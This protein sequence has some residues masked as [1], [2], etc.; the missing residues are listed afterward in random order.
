MVL[1]SLLSKAGA[2]ETC[3]PDA[4]E[5]V[6]APIASHVLYGITNGRRLANNAPDNVDMIFIGDSILEGWNKFIEAD[7]PNLSIWNFSVGSDRT[8]NVLWRFSILDKYPKN[9]KAIVLLIGTNNFANWMPSCAINAGIDEII[10]NIDSRWPNSHLFI[11]DILP[12]GADFKQYEEE[13]VAVNLHLEN[14]ATS[15]GK[16]THIN[17]D[18]TSFTCNGGIPVGTVFNSYT[19]V[20]SKV[21]RCNN[22]KDDNVHL[23]ED[24]YSKLKQAL[25]DGSY[26]TSVEGMLN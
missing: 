18:S 1:A 14:V 9:P 26:G 21:L 13:R 22:Y 16:I 7:F 6:K 19:G 12:R 8:Q 25:K 24:G 5:M 15:S 10:S 11:I 2:Q 23:T 4:V 3:S 17:L 20:S